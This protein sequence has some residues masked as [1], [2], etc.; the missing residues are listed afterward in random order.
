MAQRDGSNSDSG[1][2][3]GTAAS[4]QFIGEPNAPL[5]DEFVIINELLTLNDANVLE[6]GCGGAQRTREIAELGGVKSI[7]ASEVDEQQHSKNLAAKAD[8]RIRFESFGAQS[9]PYP[10]GQ[11]DAVLMFKSLH[12]VPLGMLDESLREIARVLRPGGLAYISEPVFAGDFNEVIRLFHDESHVRQQ[13]F[14]AMRRAVQQ[15]VLQLQEERFFESP[16]SLSSFAQ[17][18]DRILNVTH[19]DHKLTAELRAQVQE[20]F[21][22]FGSGGKY[23]FRVPHR[24]DLLRAP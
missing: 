21:E 20:K 9:I 10:D 14:N 24:V 17:F 1:S 6:L 18:A 13:A 2:D 8:P 23:E 22:S 3:S 7:V 4:M 5:R 15:D 16:I 19:T 12:H 11:F